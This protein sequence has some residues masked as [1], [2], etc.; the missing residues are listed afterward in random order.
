MP[1]S[2]RR[3][4]RASSGG[5][6]CG[7]SGANAGARQIRQPPPVADTRGMRQ[8]VAR[9]GPP[10]AGLGRDQ[11]ERAQV[12]VGWRVQVDQALLTELH[13]RHGSQG[14]GQRPHAEDRVL[15]DRAAG[16][17]VG[18]A[19]GEDPR[20]GVLAQDRQRE[21]GRRP[22]AQSLGDGAP[23]TGSATVTS[24]PVSPRV[25]MALFPFVRESRH[26]HGSGIRR[27]WTPAGV[28]R[29]AQRT[30]RRPPTVT[31][32]AGCRRI[33]RSSHPSRV[34]PDASPLSRRGRRHR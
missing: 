5:R 12:V 15:T 24:M 17:D 25:A 28:A 32:A 3:A 30:C 22:A 9:G 1:G 27:W 26:A 20:R 13:H 7:V 21:S 19:M 18:H 34:V 8:G 4:G 14:L 10:E 23:E 16:G 31:S 29:G 6:P 33:D 2:T 11:P